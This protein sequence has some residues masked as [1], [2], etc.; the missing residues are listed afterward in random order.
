MKRFLVT[1]LALA[2]LLPFSAQI[3][4]A[5]VEKKPYYAMGWSDINRLKFPNLE[6]L[7][8]IAI[9][10]GEDKTVYLEFAGAK[11]IPTIA[12]KLKS[13]MDKY[14]EGMRHLMLFNTSLPFKLQ[15]ED[16]IFMDVGAAQLKQLVTDLLKEYSAIGGKLESLSMDT[17]YI[18]LRNWYIYST[19]HG[20]LYTPTNPNIYNE[21]VE[22][23]KYATQIRPLLV[24]RGFTFYENVGGYKSEIYSM[25][26][27]QYIHDP[28]KEK[29]SNCAAIWNAVMDI[30]LA[31]YLNEAVYEPLM[32]YY[33]NAVLSDYQEPDTYAWLKDLGDAGD[34]VYLGGNRVKVGNATNT[35]TYSSRPSPTFFVD[36]NGSY[37]YQKPIAYNH[38][39]YEDDPYHML[40]WDI[41]KFKNTYAATDMKKLTAW[42]TEYDYST[43]EGSASNTPYYT[44]TVYHIGLLN[45]EPFLIFIWSGYDKYKGPNGTTEYNNRMKVIS[46]IMYEL[47][48]VAGYADRRP[49]ET[50]ASWND[51]YVLSGMYAGGR[52][53]WR[54]TPDIT[55][56]DTLES[57]LVNGQD[58]TF[59]FNGKTITFPQG[60]ILA[61]GEVSVVG[62]CGYWIE[63]PKEV[64]P[65]VTT[66]PDRYSKYPSFSEDFED[67]APGTTFSGVTAKPVNCWVVSENKPTVLAQNGNQMLAFTGTSAIRTVNLPARITAGDT[68]AKQQVWEATFLLPAAM[69]ANGEIKL[70]A[71]GSDGGIKLQDGKVY[72][73]ENG[74]YRE[75]SGVSLSAGQKYTV[76]RQVDFRDAFACDYTL[77]DGEGKILAQV[78]SVP[79]K[80]ISL[81]VTGINFS[82]TDLT[83]QF[84][85]DD[86]KLYP[87]GLALD[88]EVYDAKTGMQ[89]QD[90]SKASHRDVAFRL[91]WLNGSDKAESREVVAMFCDA[92]G[93]PVSQKVIRQVEMLPGCDGVETGIVQ[94]PQGQTVALQWRVTVDAPTPS[95]PTIPTTE[96]T[97]APTQ[98]TSTTTVPT[99]TAPTTAVP[100]EESTNPSRETTPAPEQDNSGNPILWIVLGVIVL[101]GAAGVLLLKKKKT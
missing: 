16:A 72:Y 37:L 68:Y 70:L 52:N 51:G 46:E 73:D 97:A 78:K 1:F 31:N 58:P 90:A 54:L 67:Y 93:N 44:E 4:S 40:L 3:T 14:P 81:P 100:T 18:W 9:R 38:S 74:T 98:P 10:E 5:E 94:V 86:Y 30:H 82:C 28:D 47:T 26:P 61:D 101:G 84:L 50:P 88:F 77:S 12:K 53:I 39:V 57:F 69:N 33:P 32:A 22:N 49:I 48:R 59:F 62:S 71:C 92:A 95:L 83:G 91:S 15:P 27:Y 35:N 75:M 56:G 2:M 96:P 8:T 11:D 79:M 6:G 29:Y 23:P 89:M 41:N 21:I 13:V 24:E 64:T 19:F 25:F 55:E 20:P 45:P 42:I 63:T 85:L 17:E 60:K 99:T 43:R 80:A 66:D 87:T 76:R 65:V 34:Q 36:N 7:P